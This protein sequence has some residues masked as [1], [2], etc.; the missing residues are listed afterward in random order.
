M[1]VYVHAVACEQ[2]LDSPACQLSLDL[3]Q[4]ALRDVEER[5]AHLRDQLS[6]YRAQL[7]VPY[8]A[9]GVATAISI[10]SGLSSLLRSALQMRRGEEPVYFWDRYV[11]SCTEKYFYGTSILTCISFCT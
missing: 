4:R 6:W 5:E 10:L 9:V 11:S 8:W 1:H 2:D 3:V 7:P